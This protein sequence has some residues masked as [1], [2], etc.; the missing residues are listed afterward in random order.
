MVRTDVRPKDARV[1]LDGRFVGRARFFNGPKGYLF[2]QP[3]SYRL[4][5]RLDG[6]APAA[7]EIDAR[8]GCRFDVKHR[9]G[10]DRAAKAEAPEGD[11]GKGRPS[12]RVF[13]PIGAGDRPAR[14]APPGGPSLELRPDLAQKTPQEP[15]PE[16]DASLRLTVRPASASV[17]LDGVLVATGEELE[18]MVGPLAI[19]SGQHVL[20]VRGEGWATRTVT[21]EAAR[22]VTAEIEVVLEPGPPG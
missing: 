3:G 16:R 17:Y 6:Y 10:R 15:T 4:E 20:E 14:T 18:K 12:Q 13:G 7:F 2:L 22:G 11:F 21:F 9:L 5:L 1:H 19:S 8:G